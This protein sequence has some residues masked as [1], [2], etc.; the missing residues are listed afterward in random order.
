V[1]IAVGMASD[2]GNK[3]SNL[4]QINHSLT[5]LKKYA[6]SFNGSAYVRDRRTLAA[7]LA[8][9]TWGPG[10]AGGSSKVL[11]SIT[12]ALGSYLPGQLN[13]I[14][15]NQNIT[16]LFQPILDM[17]LDEVVGHESLI[18]GPVGTPLEFPDALFQTARTSSL[19]TDLDILCMKKIMVCAQEFHKDMKLFVNIFPETLL[20]E[21][22]LFEEIL[23]DPLVGH[24]NLIFELAGSQRASDANDLF[25]TLVRLKDKGIKICID[26]PF[27]VVP[28]L[29]RP[30]VFVR[31]W[32]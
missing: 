24:V 7:Q 12:N 5:Q 11:E 3:F 4:G 17:K 20:E 16:V 25:S 27:N 19:V 29:H 26:K 22:R 28:G 8:E 14:I 2:E 6:K 13:D 32:H 15:K 30:A 21:K 31:Y 23:A 9:F 10:S 1:S 18:R